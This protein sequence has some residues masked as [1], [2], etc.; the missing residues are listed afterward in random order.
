M[1]GRSNSTKYVD[2][3]SEAS[4]DYELIVR[5]CLSTIQEFIQGG[6][7]NSPLIFTNKEKLCIFVNCIL[8][9]I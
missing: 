3:F 9:S 2:W 7:R 8:Y 4:H 5:D 1:E 6:V